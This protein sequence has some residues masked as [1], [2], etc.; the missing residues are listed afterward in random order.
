MF[1]LGTKEWMVLLV[2]EKRKRERDKPEEEGRRD[3]RDL[4]QQSSTL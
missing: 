1:V 4:P 2:E 3:E